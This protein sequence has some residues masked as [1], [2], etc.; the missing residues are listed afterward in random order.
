MRN[1]KGKQERHLRLTVDTKIKW[2]KYG[3]FVVS[4]PDRRRDSEFLRRLFG[5]QDVQ[6][7]IEVTGAVQKHWS[8]KP[9]SQPLTYEAFQNSDAVSKD[10]LIP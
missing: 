4:I 3:C 1:K 10:K 5:E 2:G 7:A 6:S 9:S 8:S